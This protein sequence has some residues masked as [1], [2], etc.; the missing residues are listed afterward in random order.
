MEIKK[1]ETAINLGEFTNKW[2]EIIEDHVAHIK[3]GH[4]TAKP[5]GESYVR[6][7]WD[8]GPFVARELEKALELIKQGKAI[9]ALNNWGQGRKRSL[10]D[11]QVQEARGYA[12]AGMP[13]FKIA[14]VFD[15]APMTA[16]NAI[17]GRGA[18][19]ES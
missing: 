9:G 19:A 11:R 5:C 14:R 7:K 17:K 2:V 1:T 6:E 15:V 13:V 12:K 8:N 10:S 4:E 16:H 3:Q 18:Y